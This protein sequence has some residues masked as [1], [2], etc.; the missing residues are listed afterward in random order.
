MGRMGADS[1]K[2][3]WIAAVVM[4]ALAVALLVAAAG[5]FLAG[6]KARRRGKVDSVPAQVTAGPATRT[7]PRRSRP[8]RAAPPSVSEPPATQP[9][10]SFEG[11]PVGWHLGDSQ[12]ILLQARPENKPQVLLV[13]MN[14][15]YEVL[16]TLFLSKND[17]VLPTRYIVKDAAWG[18]AKR[19]GGQDVLLG[20][21]AIP[22]AQ[23]DGRG[24]RDAVSQES[25]WQGKTV[26]AFQM[27]Y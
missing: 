2:T 3:S 8:R 5:F 4:A 27:D 9:Q 14:E 16:G 15:H 1:R 21:A 11:V 17:P 6:V 19:F 22:D 24:F 25:W 10:E 13:V 12:R 23:Q 7:P 18:Q 20:I 26:A